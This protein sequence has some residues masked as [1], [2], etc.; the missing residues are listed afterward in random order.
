MEQ[1][2][3]GLETPYLDF[4]YPL[5]YF[6]PLKIFNE[7]RPFLFPFCDLNGIVKIGMGMI[8]HDDSSKGGRG[9]A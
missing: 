3:S 2:P 8:A 4:Q 7:N 6:E 9:K 1:I 5:C